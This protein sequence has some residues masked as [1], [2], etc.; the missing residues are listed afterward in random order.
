VKLT[1]KQ[2][3]MKAIVERLQAYVATYSEQAHYLDYS[4]TI[5][6]DDILYGLGL[7]LDKR[8]HGAQGFESFKSMLRNRLADNGGCSG[9]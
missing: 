4:D 6:I 2:K 7:A 5:F 1:R 9:E 3:R 8:H